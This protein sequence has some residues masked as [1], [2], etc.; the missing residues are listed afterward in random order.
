MIVPVLARSTC[1]IDGI[2][3]SQMRFSAVKQHCGLQEAIRQQ[4]L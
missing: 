4:K 3:Q 1:T 2:A